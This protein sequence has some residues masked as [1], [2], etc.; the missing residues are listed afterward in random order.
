MSAAREAMADRFWRQVGEPDVNGCRH[1]LGARHHA[2][3]YGVFKVGVGYQVQAHAWDWKLSFHGPL[4]AEYMVFCHR[5]DVHYRPGSHE[6]RPCCEP[7]HIFPGTPRDNIA[8]AMQKGRMA[9]GDRCATSKILEAEL[10]VIRELLVGGVRQVDIA[11]MYKVGQACIS[12]IKR[13]VRV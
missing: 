3:N 5:C 10:P 4:P 12:R 2:T 9:R 1:W 6:Y 13:G 11:A 8:D 7:S